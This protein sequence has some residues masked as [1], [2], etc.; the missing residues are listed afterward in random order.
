M[1]KQFLM[2]FI[3]LLIASLSIVSAGNNT[4]EINNT[5]TLYIDEPTIEAMESGDSNISFTDGYKGYCIEW[6]EHSAEKGEKFYIESSS[7]INKNTKEDV[8]NYLKT[9]FFL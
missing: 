4:T 2:F 5:T 9:M 3:F 1:N 8:S 6:G 7:T